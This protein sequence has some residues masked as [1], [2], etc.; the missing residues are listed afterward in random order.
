[1]KNLIMTSKR[2]NVIKGTALLLAFTVS[3]I[4]VQASLFGRHAAASPQAHAPQLLTGRIVTRQSR[5]VTVNGN[6]VP[7]GTTVLSGAQIQTAQETG[8]TI[9]LGS[10]GQL[11][12][13]PATKL[14]LTFTEGTVTVN[15]Q[16]GYAVLTTNKGTKGSVINPQG[17]V[18][19]TDPSKVSSVMVSVGVPGPNTATIGMLPSAGPSVA[20]TMGMF[21]FAA[22]ALTTGGI[23]SSNGRGRGRNLSPTTPRGS[24]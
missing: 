13:G 24:R 19:S 2:W 11:D 12:I 8:A 7:S 15:L 5:P 4:G 9:E 3:Q 23:A 14:T 16:S 21:G 10:L 17:A 20:S 6:S 18:M 1:M 22:A